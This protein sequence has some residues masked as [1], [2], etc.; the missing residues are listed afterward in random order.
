MIDF[1]RRWVGRATSAVLL[2]L[3]LAACATLAPRGLQP[4]K[5]PNDSRDYRLI[6][7]DNQMQVLLI[8]DP[9]TPTAAAALDVDTGSAYNPPGRGGLAHFLEHMLFLGTDKYPD[10]AA[11]EQFIT[12]HGG[13]RN[14]YTGFERT[15]FFFD[16]DAPYLPDALDRFAQFFIAPRF[17]TQYVDREKNAVEAEYQMGLTSDARRDL[18]VLQALMNPQHPFSQFAIGSLE[19]LADQPGAPVRGDLL[20]FYNSH[21]SANLMRLV[22]LGSQP[23]D[24]LQ[25]MVV[26]MFTPVP[27]KSLA[28]PPIEAPLFPAGSMP[29]LVQVKPQAA[30]RD[31]QVMFP[32]GDYSKDYRTKPLAYLSNLVGHEGEGS[33]LSELKSEGLAESLAAGTGLEWSGGSL[34]SVDITLTEKGIARYNRVLQLLFAY[35]DMLRRDGPQQWLYDEQAKL[36]D[37]AFRFQGKSDPI[38]YVSRLADGM[39]TYSPEDVLRGPYMMTDYQPQM[40]TQLL[41]TVTPANALVMLQDASVATDRISPYYKAPYSVQS[42][43][44]RV[45]E[46]WQG[47]VPAG[48]FHLPVPNEFIADDVS[49]VTVSADAA[50]VPQ[51]VL[52][53]QRVE[54]WFAQDKQ[55]RVPRGATYINFRS[56]LVGQGVRQTASAALYTALLKDK[57]NEFAYPASLAGLDFSFYRHAQGITLRISG[58]NDKQSLLLEDLLAT[59]AD[60]QFDEQ[61]F[62]NIRRDMIR[63]LE[64]TAAQPPSQQVMDDLRE[65]LVYGEWS[66]DALKQALQSLNLADINAYAASFWKSANAQAMIYGNYRKG[67]VETL[68]GELSSVLPAGAPPALPPLKVVKLAAGESVLYPVDV[69]HDDAVLAWYLQGAGDTWEDRAATA[70]TA[71]I[72]KS[73]FF[74]KLRTEQQLG[75]AVVSLYWPQLDVPGMV[76]LIQSPVADTATLAAAM[77]QFLQGVPKDLDAQQFERHKRALVNEVLRPD[78][79]LWQRAEYFWQSIARKQYQFDGRASLASAVENL[80]LEQWQRYFQTVFL[81]RQ[82]SLQVAAPGARQALPEGAARQVDSAGALKAGHA[83]YV[84]E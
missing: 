84:V 1:N 19:T 68:A 11:Y 21:Y 41:D 75:Y 80:S 31:L 40:L 6:T 57:V 35:L 39:Q 52:E 45:P 42:L 17:D 69:S 10:A 27:N 7:L 12:E 53:D 3:L 81:A 44:G 22:V 56:P 62:E 32:V 49:L 20:S 51:R 36:A 16:V 60:P 8:S 29:M 43:H 37:I 61:R 58:Y 82:H 55:F 5:S 33:L 25:S 50:D 26:P 72:I 15:N 13:D 34:F 70:L 2:S 83:A 71:Q 73:G 77:S 59:I 14:A 28:V 24:E 38:N 74:Q 76:M 63:A 46:A 30:S 66:K 9:N 54:I 78:E 18:D 67:A 47:A 23:L 64:N 79:N 65:A 4:A 48:M